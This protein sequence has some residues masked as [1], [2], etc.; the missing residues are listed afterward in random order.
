[1]R[2]LWFIAAWG[3]EQ[4]LVYLVNLCLFIGLFMQIRPIIFFPPLFETTVVREVKLRKNKVDFDL[5]T[6]T[7]LRLW[8]GGLWV[9]FFVFFFS[10]IS[11][12][13]SVW[14][15]PAEN[16]SLSSS[17][18]TQCSRGQPCPG[19]SAQGCL[20]PWGKIWASGLCQPSFSAGQP[21]SWGQSGVTW[22]YLGVSFCGWVY[23]GL[24]KLG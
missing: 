17:K 12:K 24:C 13:L 11:L 8:F 10:W 9:L 2:L 3:L 1:M 4:K 21:S 6:R 18:S 20:H 23:E 22:L 16:N 19:C 14:W 15:C 5:K 7:G